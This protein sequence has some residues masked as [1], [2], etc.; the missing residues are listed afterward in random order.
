MSGFDNKD[1]WVCPNDRE[2]TLR[3]KLEAGWSVKA[4]VGY[5]VSEQ[6]ISDAEQ[7]AILEVIKRAQQVELMEKNRIGRLIDRL[8]NM[9]RNAKGDGNRYCA[10]CNDEFGLFGAHCH[11]C[12]DC[13]K[14]VC[15]KCG[16]DTFTSDKE[17]IWLCKICSE[18]REVNI[19]SSIF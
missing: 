16:V 6:T 4:G 11:H 2:L 8:N 1:R 17:P 14:A 5:P 7:K 3:A 12:K 19:C 13:N 15:S 10:L 18:T 9:K